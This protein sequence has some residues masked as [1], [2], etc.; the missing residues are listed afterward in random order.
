MSFEIFVMRI[1]LINKF[2]Y[3]HGGADVYFLNLGRLLQGAGHQVAYFSQHHHGESTNQWRPYFVDE[4]DFSGARASG[5]LAKALRFCYSFEAKKKLRQLLRDFQPEVIHL[6]NIYHHL[7]SAVLDV[8]KKYP[9]PKVMTLHDFKL[10]C[11]N[12]K[13]FTQGEICERC[14]P[15]HYGQAVIHRC[16]QDSRTASLVAALEMSWTKARQIYEKTIDCFIAPSNFLAQKILAWQT[17][18][19]RLEHLPNFV[20]LDDLTPEFMPG[21]YYLYFGRLSPEKG[22]ANLLQAFSQ[23]PREKLKIVGQGPLAPSLRE[24]IDTH[25]LRNIAL[26]GFKQKDELYPIIRAS[27]AVI[28]PSLLPDIY[29]FSIIEAQALGK[30]VIASR[31]GGMPE[32][33]KEGETGYLYNPQDSRE[34]KSKIV[35]LANHLFLLPEMGRRARARVEAENSPT[36]HLRALESLYRS[37]MQ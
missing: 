16:V 9:A 14:F 20:F 6:H 1:L 18:V 17:T 37:L 29:P 3:P 35:D 31:R 30:V 32:M 5:G 22:L 15:R 19:K 12:Y 10:I 8:L 2:F 36:H 34:L 7:T 4:V 25:D 33:I 11:P 27:R 24:F 28:V 23:L 13:L 26:L 21:D